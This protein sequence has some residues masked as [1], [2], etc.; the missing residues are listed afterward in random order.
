MPQRTKQNTSKVHSNKH[1]IRVGN[2]VHTDCIFPQKRESQDMSVICPFC[3]H[4]IAKFRQTMITFKY[5]WNKLI[6]TNIE[7][8]VNSSDFTLT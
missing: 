5:V 4:Q 1:I 3:Y 7:V 2:A 6:K 8:K